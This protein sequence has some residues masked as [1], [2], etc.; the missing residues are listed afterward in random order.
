MKYT[1]FLVNPSKLSLVLPPFRNIE[2]IYN[3]ELNSNVSFYTFNIRW[4]W[5]RQLFQ[6]SYSSFS[7]APSILLEI[8]SLQQGLPNK[9]FS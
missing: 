9:K 3:L 6:Y 1:Y 4:F 2:N 5:F 7:F 8:W